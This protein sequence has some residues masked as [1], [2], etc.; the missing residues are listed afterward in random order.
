MVTTKLDLQSPK[1]QI[2]I[3]T[4]AERARQAVVEFRAQ[5]NEDVYRA[6]LSII[7]SESAKGAVRLSLYHYD[8]VQDPLV[9]NKSSSDRYINGETRVAINVASLIDTSKLAKWLESDGFK[10]DTMD[11]EDFVTVIDTISWE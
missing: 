2:K 4:P 5:C 10:V 6:L 11:S 9:L 7:E 3:E 8:D 1:A